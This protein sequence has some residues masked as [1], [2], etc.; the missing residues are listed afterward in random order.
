MLF[1]DKASM[2]RAAFRTLRR[3]ARTFLAERLRPT[4]ADLTQV[5]SQLLTYGRRLRDW[6]FFAD[7]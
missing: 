4:A 1:I 3:A 5:R 7:H 6:G 2:T